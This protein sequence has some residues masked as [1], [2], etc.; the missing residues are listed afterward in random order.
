MTEP[1]NS[2]S[3][4]Q[5]VLSRTELAALGRNI[6]TKRVEALG[7]TVEPPT[8]RAGSKLAVRTPSGRALEVY[9]STQRVGGYAFW[10]KDRFVPSPDRLVAIVL[11]GTVDESAV[12]LLASLEWRRAAPPLTD[13]DN[14]G[15]R[16]KPEYGVSLARSSL[17]ALER[18]RWDEGSQADEFR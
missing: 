9:V 15:K 10:T 5:A 6:V 18:Y 7:C 1:S 11:L 16:S 14:I 17:P 13:R 2:T 3:A 12:Y 8:G 4:P